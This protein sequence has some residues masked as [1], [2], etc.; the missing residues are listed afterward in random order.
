MDQFGCSRTCCLSSIKNAILIKGRY[1]ETEVHLIFRDIL[2]QYLRDLKKAK[3]L[4]INLIRYPP[5]RPP[6]IQVGESIVFDRLTGEEKTI[7]YDLL[8]IATPLIPHGGS[9]RIA[10]L[11]R[12]KTDNQGFLIEN[13]IKLRPGEYIPDGIFVAGSAHWPVNISE[14]IF[15]GYSAASRTAQFLAEGDILG[16]HI[17]AS[18]DEDLCRGCGYC[19]KLCEFNAIEI[20]KD[21][22]GNPKAQLN[23]DICKGCGI[24]VVSCPTGALSLL[25]LNNRQIDSMLQAF[26]GEPSCPVGHH[27]A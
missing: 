1:P 20:L 23:P 26:L 13:Q 8:V 3:S 10:E 7:P 27:E 14:A 9:K 24:C 15:Q 16:E 25:E 6:A 18:L 11:L 4:G 21:E 5:A 22:S 19:T 2:T 17:I 12:I